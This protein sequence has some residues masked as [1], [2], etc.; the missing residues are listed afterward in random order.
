MEELTQQ[1]IASVKKRILSA[2]IDFISFWIVMFLLGYFFGESDRGKITPEGAVV[3]FGYSFKGAASILIYLAWFLFFPVMETATGFT[4]GKKI[5]GLKVVQKN[6]RKISFLK[7]IIR[8]LVDGV[9]IFIFT[10]YIIA[11]NNRY[12][13]RIGDLLANTIVV[14][15]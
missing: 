15:A 6:G 7:S 8:H 2:I 5:L 3:Q 1:P 4:V 11:N 14:K 12:H 9:D 10:G 13:Q